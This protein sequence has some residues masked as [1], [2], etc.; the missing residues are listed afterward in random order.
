MLP[1]NSRAT[2]T[3]MR[4]AAYIPTVLALTLGSFLVTPTHAAD[5][6]AIIVG[7][8]DLHGAIEASI[9]T[10]QGAAL[11]WGGA[12]TFSGYVQILRQ[13]YGKRLVLLDA[14]D[15]FQGT[16][17][18]NLS[19]GRA[20]VDAYNVLGYSAVAVGNH[21]F[22]FGAEAAG[23]DRLGV[24]KARLVQAHFPFLAVNI[25]DRARDAPVAWPN[26]LPSAVVQA[27][28]IRVGIIGAATPE[29][30]WTTQP[31]NIAPLN[32]PEPAPLIAAEA[33]RLRQQQVDLVVLLA[34]VG[35]DCDMSQ[36][37]NDTSHCQTDAHTG[38]LLRLL[39]QLPP[40]T[41]DVAVGGHTHK[42]M[43][44]WQGNTAIIES[45]ARGQYM[46]WVEACVSPH[47]GLERRKSAIHAATPLCLDVWQDGGCKPR[48]TP[49][50]GVAAATFLGAKVTPMPALQRA[51]QP[52]LEA[53]R[54]AADRPL[55]INLPTALSVEALT[56]V[57]A[58]GLRRTAQADF[59]IQNHGGIRT[60]LPAGKLT[61]GQVYQALPFDNFVVR[62][63]RTGRQLTDLVRA[64]LTRPAEAQLAL[65]GLTWIPDSGA[66]LGK[67]LHHDGQPLADDGLYTVA[68]T[69]FL[70]AGGDGAAFAQLT[71]ADIQVQD[72]TIRDATIRLLVSLYPD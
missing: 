70:V 55:G 69:D 36:D 59:G 43:G 30:A 35:G 19:Q 22:D 34:H 33:H 2:F 51:M 23:V 10:Q 7:T 40:G 52:Y 45:G 26:L 58:E 20:V 44:H 49:S 54:S 11:R 3:N 66:D 48:N 61:F 28:D 60:A 41:I 9:L 14:G 21:E 71:P 64:A 46:A 24:L 32:F 13:R 39:A 27:G 37:A 12:T 5:R 65:A 68:T 38:A 4:K 1:P 63:H 6:C 8:N 42:F 16:M 56:N 47:G 25:F 29:T 67:L 50:P 72:D 15:L 18:S 53:V 31:R 17:V 62:I 57:T